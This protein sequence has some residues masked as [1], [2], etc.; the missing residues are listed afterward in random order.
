LAVQLLL[1]F[2]DLL[3][4]LLDFYLESVAGADFFET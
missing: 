3:F 2:K 4:E 1:E